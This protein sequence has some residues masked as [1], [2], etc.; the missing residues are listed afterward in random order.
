VLVTD[1][2]NVYRLSSPETNLKEY[3]GATV[4]ITG[5][6]DGTDLS[7]VTISRASNRN[8]REK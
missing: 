1:N 2:Y 8:Q 4:T 5:V 3:A 7:V 6:L